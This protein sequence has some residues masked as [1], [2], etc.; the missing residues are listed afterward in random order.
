MERSDELQD[1]WQFVGAV[2]T[3]L[4]PLSLIKDPLID[5]LWALPGYVECVVVEGAYHGSSMALGQMIS[6]FDEIDT[7][8][9]IEGFTVGRSDEE[10]D[11]IGLG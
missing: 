2:C 10:L 3:N 1:L 6:H 9:I 11:I 5:R 4:S 7:V 8:V